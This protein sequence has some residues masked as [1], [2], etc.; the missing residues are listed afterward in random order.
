MSLK[1]MNP[2]ISNYHTC[3]V[4]AIQDEKDVVYQIKR[5]CRSLNSWDLVKLVDQT[6]GWHIR[7]MDA[8]MPCLW[9]FHKSPQVTV[10]ST[11]LGWLKQSL[12]KA[13]LNHKYP[14]LFIAV[15][16]D[17]IHLNTEEIG[18]NDRIIASIVSELIYYFDKITKN[19]CAIH[20]YGSIEKYR[21]ALKMYENNDSSN[22]L[23]FQSIINQIIDRL[24]FG[25]KHI[26]DTMMFPLWY[27]VHTVLN[28][29]CSEPI[30][31]YFCHVLKNWIKLQHTYSHK[32]IQL[33]Q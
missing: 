22:K 20:K 4:I 10:S 5:L 2:T 24:F 33:K 13:G 28:L 23:F 29:R 3:K 1:L 8:T 32:V 16:Y 15:I 11:M 21:I 6:L 30:D 27:L 18:K 9:S 7:L 12:K 25:N 14:R 31:H 19:C 26:I 17:C